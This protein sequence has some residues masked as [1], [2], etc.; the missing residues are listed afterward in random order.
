MKKYRLDVQVERLEDGR[1]LATSPNLRG[2]LAERDTIADAIENIEDV[3]RVLL[4]LI[5]EDGLPTPARL[6]VLHADTIVKAQVVVP[7][8]E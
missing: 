4:D 3:A 2:C 7:A 5:K 8:P 6:E 1:F